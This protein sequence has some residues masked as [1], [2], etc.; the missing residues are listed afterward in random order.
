LLKRRCR[1]AQIAPSILLHVS[2]ERPGDV[3][4]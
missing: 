2:R 3:K 1:R 4:K